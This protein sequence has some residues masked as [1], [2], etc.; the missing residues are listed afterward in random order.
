MIIRNVLKQPHGAPLTT[1][2]RLGYLILIKS[3]WKMLLGS[4]VQFHEVSSLEQYHTW[5][6][7]VPGSPWANHISCLSCALNSSGLLEIPKQITTAVLVQS[8]MEAHGKC[9]LRSLGQ[10]SLWNYDWENWLWSWQSLSQCHQMSYS[11]L[12]K[13]LCNMPGPSGADWLIRC[14]LDMDGKWSCSF[15]GRFHHISLSYSFEELME[16]GPGASWGAIPSDILTKKC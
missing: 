4:M 7:H 11:I 8:S 2:Y 15:L 13:N 10:I 1:S 9:A 16:N 6:G 12:L 14:C 3:W 5:V